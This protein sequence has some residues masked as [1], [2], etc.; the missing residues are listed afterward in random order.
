MDVRSDMYAKIGS[1]T[2]TSE[3]QRESSRQ[4]DCVNKGYNGRRKRGRPKTR[5]EVACQRDMKGTE[6]GQGTWSRTIVTLVIP[7]TLHDGKNQGGKR[8][9][10]Q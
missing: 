10:Q 3:E 9:S 1:G 6:D 8:L 7:A 2:N 4:T 5:W